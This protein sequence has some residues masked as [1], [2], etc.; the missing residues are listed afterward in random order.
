VRAAVAHYDRKLGITAA[1]SRRANRA[2][3]AALAGGVELT[4]LELK[5]VL[6]RSGVNTEGTQ[7]LAHVMMH[8]EL[9][10]IVCSGAR[11]GKQFTYALLDDRVPPAPALPRDHAL[12]ELARR[13]FTGHGPAQLRDFAWW[14][15]LTTREARAGL[16]MARPQLAEEEI[17][18]RPYWLGAGARLSVKPVPSAWLLPPYDE[19]LIGYR[20][21]SAALDPG[22]WNPMA[23]RDAFLAPVVLGGRVVGGWRR[24]IHEE[25]VAV[26]LELPVR[27]CRADARLIEDAARRYGDF[28]GLEAV[29]ESR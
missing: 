4:R 5:A 9:D 25:A 26:A 16:E 12:A 17:D 7:R 24:T 14:S 3:A 15:G 8:A 22:L 6:E 11:R 1:L 19:Y 28:L 29:I 10:A 27:L 13:Y 20:D 18:G 2:I 23:R 21:R